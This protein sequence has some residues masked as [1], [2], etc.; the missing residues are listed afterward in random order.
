MRGDGR[1]YREQ[2]SRFWWMAYY[3]HGRYVRQSTEE[4]DENKARKILRKRIAAVLHGD[5]IPD[6]SGHRPPSM[7]KRYHIIALNDLRRAAERG[8]AY[9]S[10]RAAGTI[11]TFPG[12]RRERAE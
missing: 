12:T 3:V 11:V 2:G 5:V 4:T 9:E 7:L 1:L 10:E 8:S 6:E